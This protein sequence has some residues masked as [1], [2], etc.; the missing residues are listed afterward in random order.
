MVDWRWTRGSPPQTHCPSLVGLAPLKLDSY[1][2]Q[3]ATDNFDSYIAIQSTKPC[4]LG[5]ALKDS[6]VA[7]LAWI[8]EKLVGWSDNYPRTDDEVL[9]GVSICYLSV[10]SSESSSYLYYEMIYEPKITLPVVQS[11]IDVPLGLADFPVEINNAPRAWW[12]TL[13]P[14]VYSK[15]YDNG[16]GTLRVGRSPMPLLRR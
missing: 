12:S 6:P 9:T 2:H 16:K 10:S 8:Y 14:V 7:L 15:S 1:Q 13:R 4:T 3:T 11:Y 5:C